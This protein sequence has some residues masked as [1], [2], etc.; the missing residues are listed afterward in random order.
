MCSTQRQEYQPVRVAANAAIGGGGS[1]AAVFEQMKQSLKGKGKQATE[2][3]HEADVAGDNL[4]KLK[5]S[6]AEMESGMAQNTSFV[7]YPTG[8]KFSGL[9]TWQCVSPR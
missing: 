3:M 2:K 8:L 9:P 5:F 6:L 7:A 4:S 1:P